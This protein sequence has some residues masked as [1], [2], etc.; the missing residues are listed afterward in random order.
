VTNTFWFFISE[1]IFDQ[2]STALC[3]IILA[4]EFEGAFGKANCTSLSERLL[5]LVKH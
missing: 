4:P 5:P 3:F 1:G 2:I